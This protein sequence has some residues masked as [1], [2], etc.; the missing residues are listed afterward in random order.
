MLGGGGRE[1]E[2]PEGLLAGYVEAE[3]SIQGA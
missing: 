3:E 1:K 2:C